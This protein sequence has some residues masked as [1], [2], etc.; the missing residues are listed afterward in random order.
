MMFDDVVGA[1]IGHLVQIARTHNL[2][3][4]NAG[5]ILYTDFLLPAFGIALLVLS[6][7]HP[8]QVR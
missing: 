7:R 3:P 5:A 2:A 8:R 6:R 4:G 1:G